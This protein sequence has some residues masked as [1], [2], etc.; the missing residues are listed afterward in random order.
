MK[1]QL[2]RSITSIQRALPEDSKLNSTRRN[3]I[4]NSLESY[5]SNF[6]VEVADLEHTCAISELGNFDVFSTTEDVQLAVLKDI[7]DE[8]D[9]G[10]S[11][12]TTTSPISLEFPYG[13]IFTIIDDENG[14]NTR[15]A[16][17]GILPFKLIGKGV[18]TKTSN[19]LETWGL[20]PEPTV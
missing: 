1:V 15:D 17:L 11:L 5:E 9:L 18:S 19:S 10:T 14:R 3:E 13:L 20:F 4:Y 12:D 8:N 16:I 6:R 2:L 7:L